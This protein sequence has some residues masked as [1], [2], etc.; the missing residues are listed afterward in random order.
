MTREMMFYRD[1]SSKE[2]FKIP[3][4]TLVD[5]LHPSELTSHEVGCLK[6]MR[7]TDARHSD[8]QSL[9]RVPFR[10][11]GGFRTGVVGDDLTVSDPRKSVG[12]VVRYGS[13]N[14]G[15]S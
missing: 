6:R 14:K 10:F 5:V 13:R 11:E 7:K 2:T 9:R 1:G 4:G 15:G 8:G 3:A 12:G